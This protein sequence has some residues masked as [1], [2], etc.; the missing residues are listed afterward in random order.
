MNKFSRLPKQKLHQYFN[1]ISL[2]QQSSFTSNSN[3]KIEST[4]QFLDSVVYRGVNLFA[5][6]RL[7]ADY[8]DSEH[9][10]IA[11]NT[12]WQKS[13]PFQK[14]LA[15]TENDGNQ[16]RNQKLRV[17]H[18]I[19]YQLNVE[20]N[21]FYLAQIIPLSCKRSIDAVTKFGYESLDLLLTF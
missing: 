19:S 10:I 20:P 11:Y 21:W 3:Q 13:N 7:R 5:S 9:T 17:L 16:T 18:G 1:M 12:L 8:N 4:I 6:E 15:E 14:K 2:I